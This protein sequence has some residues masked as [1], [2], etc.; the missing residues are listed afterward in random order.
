[1]GRLSTRKHRLTGRIAGAVLA[2]AT[3]A[4]LAAATSPDAIV[5]A[6]VPRAALETLAGSWR[7]S[8][9]TAQASVPATWLPPLDLVL[10]ASLGPSLAT[11][12]RLKAVDPSDNGRMLDLEIVDWLA[13]EAPSSGNARSQPPVIIVVT[14]EIGEGGH[15]QR[16]LLRFVLSLQ[17]AP[18]EP[19]RAPRQNSL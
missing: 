8:D 15:T 10:P 9:D 7:S 13:V 1:M 3:L 17:G 19:V 18:T 6:E 5:A 16:P 4:S 12:T 11:G 14:R 2:V